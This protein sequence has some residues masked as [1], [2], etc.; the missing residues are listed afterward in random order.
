MVRGG[1]VATLSSA[2]DGR[3]GVIRDGALAV[4]GDR[5]EW[6]GPERDAPSGLL[7]DPAETVELE[8]RW[9][10]PGL[11]DAHTH[12]VFGGHRAEEFALRL[13]GVSYQEIAR[14]DGGI[15]ATVRATR[16]STSEELLAGGQRRLET[17]I[18]H[19]L[20][21]VEVKSGYGLDTETE[22][23][24][25]RV[26]RSL[27]ARTGVTVRTTLL[28]AHAVPPEYQGD[29]TAYLDQVCQDLIPA[30]AADG[31]ADAVDAFC[32]SIAFTP[33]ECERVLR[34]GAREGL[35]L[36]LHADQLEDGGGAALAARLR[37][38][39]ADHL[40]YASDEG[41]AAMGAAGTA[42]VLLPG[43]YLTLRESHPPPVD[44][45]RRE[46]VPMVV[47]TDLNPG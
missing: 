39:S 28:A 12:L 37:A 25:L 29:R 3:F 34:T 21:T 16:R 10:T 9:A 23:R 14:R 2:V 43:A 35:D 33:S 18:D 42:A 7:A 20:T 40:E 24:M 32:E 26:A 8:G 44:A 45:L 27:E 38:R 47:A 4:V 11:V 36:R 5:I 46:G 17:M 30:A 1:T 22:L 19:G 6:V 13:Q 31:L 15:L 41:V